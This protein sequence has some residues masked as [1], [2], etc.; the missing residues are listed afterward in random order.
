ME[1]SGDEKDANLG[2]GNKRMMACPG[3]A[4]IRVMS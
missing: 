3:V 2:T 1:N 4:G